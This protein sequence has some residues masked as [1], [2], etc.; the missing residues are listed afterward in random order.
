MGDAQGLQASLKLD[1]GGIFT[2]ERRKAGQNVTKERQ[3][4]TTFLARGLLVYLFLSL[5]RRFSKSAREGSNGWSMAIYSCGK[6]ARCKK[7]AAVTTIR[8]HATDFAKLPGTVTLYLQPLPTSRHRR[9][10]LI[11]AAGALI[12]YGRA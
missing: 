1:V 12:G 5:D 4:A 8:C 9:Q 6:S 2:S 7:V 3:T 10:G 11:P